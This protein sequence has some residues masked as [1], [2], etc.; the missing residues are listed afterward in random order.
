MTI[1]WS[2]ALDGVLFVVNPRAGSG[3]A[4][5]VWRELCATHPALREARVIHRDYLEDARSAMVAAL[6]DLSVQRLIVVGGDGTVDQACNVLLDQGVAGRVAVGLIPVGTGADLARGFHVHRQPSEA[7]A[8][9]LNGEVR[10]LDV[11]R[12]E[13]DEGQHYV[14]NI[15]SVGLSSLVADK[16]NARRRRN[17][18]TYLLAALRSLRGYRGY[19]CEVWLDGEPWYRGKVLL[20]A[21]ANGVAF[22]RGMRIAPRAVQDDGLMDVVLVLPAPIWRILPQIPRLYKGT[23]LSA[24]FVRFAQTARL[25]VRPADDVAGWEIDGESFPPGPRR[26]EVLPD[27]LRL[28]V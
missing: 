1:D 24:S 10:G 11:I 2:T 13:G 22:G 25:E 27:A 5:R 8:H 12:A 16:V 23:H 17:T 9:A 26:F 28:V 14:V 15:A 7:L 3:R 6:A 18:L 19:G 20:L 4:E 21:V